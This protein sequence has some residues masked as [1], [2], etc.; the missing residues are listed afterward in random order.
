M[1]KTQASTGL[2][3]KKKQYKKLEARVEL[4]VPKLLKCSYVN[5]KKVL[6]HEFMKYRMLD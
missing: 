1:S 4:Y 2:V 5:V 3:Y 6:M